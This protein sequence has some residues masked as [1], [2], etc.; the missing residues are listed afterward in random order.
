MCPLESGHDLQPMSFISMP[1]GVTV[2]TMTM[3]SPT[4][5]RIA[6]FIAPKL[7]ESLPGKSPSAP[8]ERGMRGLPHHAEWP[9]GADPMIEA[10]TGRSPE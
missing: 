10:A 8:E 6:L 9:K 5:D 2:V 7:S 1:S 3:L 4:L